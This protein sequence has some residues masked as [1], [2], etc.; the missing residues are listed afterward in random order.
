MADFAKAIP[1]I[2]KHEG[3]FVNHRADPGGVTNYGISLRFLINLGDIDKDS[4]PDGDI[5][6]DG[7]VNVED[8][9]LLTQDQASTFYKLHFWDRNNY[10]KMTSQRVATKVFDLAV[11]MG[12]L[13]ANKLLQRAINKKFGMH[14]IADGIIGSK[15][16]EAVN[17]CKESAIIDGLKEEARQFYND[18]VRKNKELFPFLKGWVNRALSD[19]IPL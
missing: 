13:Q 15:T 10:Q 11:N 4:W 9:K 18:L 7:E 3:R 17:M 2:F 14:L 1:T 8:V 12:S 6:H 19:P 16:I 5:N